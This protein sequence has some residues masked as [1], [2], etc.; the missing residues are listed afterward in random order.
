MNAGIRPNLA[1][2]LTRLAVP[3]NGRDKILF[4][5]INEEVTKEVDIFDV[6][7]LKNTAYC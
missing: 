6:T 1:Y 2:F 4:A 3:W 7:N 5:E